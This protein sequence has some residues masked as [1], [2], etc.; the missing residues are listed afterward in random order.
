MTKKVSSQGDVPSGIGI[1]VQARSAAGQK[2]VV[3]LAADHGS[4]VA[5]VFEL[6]EEEAVTRSAAQA[7]SRSA[8]MRRLAATPPATASLPYPFRREASMA[9]GTRLSLTA[10][11]KAGGERRAGPGASPFCWA[12]WIRFRLAVLR[13]EKDMSSSC[14]VDVGPGQLISAAPVP[15]VGQAVHG[16][17]AR[18]ADAEHPAP[19]CRSTRRPASSRV[20]P[21]M[22][23]H[24]C[25]GAHI[26]DGGGAAGDAQAD[27]G[28]LQ[29]RGG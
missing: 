12:L 18:I 22:H 10:R 3:P 29:V 20:V 9:R 15:P 8:R 4:V 24:L 23:L 7:A 26:H 6:R 1:Q 11:P 19:P 28:G 25:I 14:P 5:A 27:E 21:P 16:S 17:A 13:P 2:L